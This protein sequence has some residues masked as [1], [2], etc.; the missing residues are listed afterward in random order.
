M[1][2]NNYVNGFFSINGTIF[3]TY[4]PTNFNIKTLLNIKIKDK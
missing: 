1:F 2:S 4:F 3:S